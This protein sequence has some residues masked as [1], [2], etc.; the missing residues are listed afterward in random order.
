M[1]RTFPRLILAIAAF[2]VASHAASAA[3]VTIPTGLNPGDQYRLT[4]VTSAT[5]DA[6]STNIADYNAFVTSAVNSVPALAALG[7]TWRAI[8]STHSIDARDNTGTNW[9]VDPV[10]VP[11]Y[12]L[13][14]SLVATSN[15]DFWD[16]S[17]AISLRV[18]EMDTLIDRDVWTGS[19]I[20]GTEY[21]ALGESFQSHY[22]RST[23]AASP[24]IHYYQLNNFYPASL[25]AMS[26]VLTVPAVPEPGSLAL[27]GLAAA[28]LAAASLGRRR[29]RRQSLDL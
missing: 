21:Y 27:A 7:T 17:H 10:G 26:D 4:F 25:Y 2:A 20:D 3:V 18:T 28:G 14:D 16:G 24:W 22:G 1:H 12:A 9:T 8:A 29:L 15:L 5:R 23:S 19:T 6:T 13:S 11:I